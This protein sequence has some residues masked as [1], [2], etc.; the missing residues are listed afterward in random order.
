MGVDN[1]GQ[2]RCR[3]N[4]IHI[5]KHPLYGPNVPALELQNHGGASRWSGK[6]FAYFA[7]ICQYH[8]NTQ[9]V[10]VLRSK[11]RLVRI[12]RLTVN[13][14]LKLS[15]INFWRLF[16]F[17]IFLRCVCSDG[18]FIITILCLSY[19]TWFVKKGH[20]CSELLVCS[21]SYLVFPHVQ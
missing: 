16:L 5:R 6:W 1:I 9:L 13:T 20:R 7:H 4:C 11:A 17:C 15:S 14:T 19:Y 3:W 18:C 21:L 2:E 12:G 10:W 8:L